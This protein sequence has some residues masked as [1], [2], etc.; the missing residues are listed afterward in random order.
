MQKFEESEEP[1][2]TRRNI[3]VIAD[4][5]HR[6]QYSLDEKVD[7][8][9][10]KITLGFARLVR[11]SF[12]NATFIGFT[13]TPISLRDRST[14]EVFGDYIDVYDMTQSVE[15]GATR[16][17]YYESRVINLVL[18]QEVLQQVDTEYG[19][20]AEQA[21]SYMVEKLSLIHIFGGSL[22]PGSMVTIL[23]LGIFPP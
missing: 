15:D 11:N 16:P 23:G 22:S 18:N 13:G 17:V 2:S 7:P 12:P 10:G 14:R 19:L 4:E 6:S 21:E 3:I 5:A 20:I 8:K 9:T 1:L